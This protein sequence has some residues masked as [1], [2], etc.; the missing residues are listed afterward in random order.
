[1]RI[2]HYIPA[3][4]GAMQWRVYECAMRSASWAA[5]H[6]IQIVPMTSKG[7]W[8]DVCRNLAVE[9]ATKRDCDL[10]YMQD[11]DCYAPADVAL[12]RL[13]ASM[14]I[15]K[16]DVVG[17]AVERRGKRR[18]MNCK[19]TLS[20]R[21]YSGTVGCGL[22]LI[23]LESIRDLPRPLF[24]R[25]LTAKGL[26]VRVGED[27]GFCRHAQEHGKRVFVDYTFETTHIA[28][29]ELCSS[30]HFGDGSMVPVETVTTDDSVRFTQT[31]T[32]TGEGWSTV[33]MVTPTA[34][35]E[36]LATGTTPKTSEDAV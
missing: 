36:S 15:A 9:D 3:Y 24:R 2:A 10:I 35:G 12:E 25:E 21:L 13:L 7:P 16:A 28:E 22:M 27:I 31:V 6:G 32:P 4:R 8:L 14:E 33:Q 29:Q 34:S 26:S 30:P 11:A 5:E 18:R 1:M 20:G 23:N 19:P 17:A